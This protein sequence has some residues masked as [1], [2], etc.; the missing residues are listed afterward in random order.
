MA[1][2]I[3]GVEPEV[4]LAALT[5]DT[6]NMDAAGAAARGPIEHELLARSMKHVEVLMQLHVRSSGATLGALAATN[7]QQRQHIE[8]LSAAHLDNVRL[9][10]ELYD[11]QQARDLVAQSTAAEQARRDKILDYGVTTVQTLMAAKMAEAGAKAQ[12]EAEKR[13]AQALAPAVQPAAAL[14]ATI[15]Q[16][17]PPAAA[18][19][20]AEPAPEK[21]PGI[22]P[23][24]E[25]MVALGQRAPDMLEDLSKVLSPDDL[26]LLQLAITAACD[27]VE[28]AVAGAEPD[29][30]E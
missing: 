5:T 27:Q 25:H 6:P 17:P 16:A 7:E 19:T 10:E 15:I 4:H 11:Q 3:F 23:A 2:H 21:P 14:A 8:T 9:R 1:S 28:Q 29:A 20:E 26:M 12:A 24:I 13:K 18:K 22:T 30:A